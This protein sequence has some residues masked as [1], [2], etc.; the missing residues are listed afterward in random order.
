MRNP[1]TWLRNQ[2]KHSRYMASSE[3]RNDSLDV[4]LTEDQRAVVRHLR[5]VPGLTG[6]RLNAIAPAHETGRFTDWGASPEE[7][8]TIELAATYTPP[9][10]ALR[11][12]YLFSARD[13]PLA[14]DLA[15]ALGY[16]D[17]PWAGCHGK[18]AGERV[19]SSISLAPYS[20]REQGEGLV[21]ASYCKTPAHPERIMAELG[22]KVN[23]VPRA[24]G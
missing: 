9:Q 4:K 10:R 12:S 1:L 21:Y 13:S 16:G 18:P 6:L 24:R 19:T 15:E 11:K 8:S 22:L 17:W 14:H 7:Y 20:M 5:G 23:L 2:D 3:E